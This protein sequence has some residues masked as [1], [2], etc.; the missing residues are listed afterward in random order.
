LE[1]G[2]EED[3][4]PTKKRDVK[5]VSCFEAISADPDIKGAIAKICAHLETNSRQ[6][7]VG[8]Y[9][10]TVQYLLISRNYL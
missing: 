9:A 4:E 6:C 10:I 7:Q 8:A 2:N 5:T 3:G 1:G